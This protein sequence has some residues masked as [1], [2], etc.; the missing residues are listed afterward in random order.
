MTNEQVVLLALA[1]GLM[2]AVV[3]AVRAYERR[4]SEAMQAV[5]YRLGLAWA[6]EIAPVIRERLAGFRLVSQGTGRK[7]SNVL[8]GTLHQIAVTLFDYRYSTGAGK[9]DRTH[10]QTV[11]LFETD[12]LH[13]P[14]FALRPE[15]VFHKLGE[16]LGHQDID[17]EAHPE[18]SAAYL[19]QG[20]DE[21]AIR[22]TF[23]EALLGYF[24]RHPGLCVEGAGQ[25]LVYYRS[26]RRVD[27]AQLGNFLEEGL[28]VVDALAR[29]DGG[30][31]IPLTLPGPAQG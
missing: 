30:L 7:A 13:L 17:F 11:L 21:G 19:L 1:I 3:L 23:G 20:P 16:A 28:D 10:I 5:A 4:R 24:A 18:F 8:H 6:P 12:R 29:K 9:S 26:G 22:D 15:H 25:Q 2:I 31:G 27:P 14:A